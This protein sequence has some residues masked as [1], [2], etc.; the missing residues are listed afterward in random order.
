MFHKKT[1][2]QKSNFQIELLYQ[3]TMRDTKKKGL[4]L[5]GSVSLRRKELPSL[6]E[7]PKALPK[8]FQETMESEDMRL[9][10]IA[11]QQGTEYQ[12]PF[13]SEPL[14]FRD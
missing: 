1:R 4:R 3:K 8:T 14:S 13:P 12:R 2:F 9:P 10:L 7:S 6:T 5:S 11:A